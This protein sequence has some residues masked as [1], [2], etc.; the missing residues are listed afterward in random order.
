MLLSKIARR[1]AVENH[2][3]Q[4]V[5]F[6]AG[7]VVTLF[8]SGI[9]PQ[10]HMSTARADRAD[11]ELQARFQRHIDYLAS[12]ELEGRG[13]GTEGIEQAAQYI[14]AQFREAGVLPASGES[15]FQTF[16]MTTEKQ[17]GECM[18]TFPGQDAELKSNRDFMP[19]A[20]SSSAPFE[21]GV[22][23]CG[24]GIVAEEQSRDDFENVDVEGRVAMIMR[25]QPASWDHVSDLSPWHKTLRNKVYNAKDRGAAAVLIVNQADDDG[26]DELVEFSHHASDAYGIP[27]MHISRR[28]ADAHLKRGGL[29]SLRELQEKLDG[30]ATASGVLGH[31][32]CKGKVEFVQRSSNTHNVAGLIR[33]KGPHANECVVIGA[34]YD[35]LGVRQP[36]MRRFKDGK[37]VKDAARPE[38]HNGADD[39]ASG[40]SA[41]IELARYFAKQKALPRS[42]LFIAFTGEE[43]GLHGSKHYIDHPLWP[44]ADTIAMLNMDM[45]G[46]LDSSSKK[47]TIFGTGTSPVFESLVQDASSRHDLVPST[48][49]DPG[50]RSDHA[51]FVRKDVPAMHFYS[52]AHPD[53][54]KPTDTADKINAGGGARITAMVRDVAESLVRRNERP[55]FVEVKPKKPKGDPDAMPSYRVV[56][57]I[58]PGYVEDGEPGMPVDAVNPN[59]PADL[60]GMKK[61]DRIV[62]IGDKEVVNIYDYMA[63]TRGN[64]PGDTVKVVV[65]RG[66][67]RVT[68]QVT[69]AAAR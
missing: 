66:D 11:S 32:L 4:R 23:F 68:L 60:G 26:E 47:L 14:A 57:G 62:S 12:D 38:I 56:M 18:L 1:Y 43:S 61:G 28:V 67:E 3:G 50:G 22:V 44:V 8:V 37:I 58:A 64:K 34:H 7:L 35:H 42:M 39:N 15:Y 19:F 2:D 16:E 6:Q 31:V 21:G 29:A 51:V 41:L 40:T 27:A 55:Q 52:G 48:T 65:V 63:A 13:V 17:L 10:V 69:L 5:S 36:M 33:G 9:L 53:Y 59:G 54:H 24:Y 49:P 20:F 30:G 46:R 25:G 45:I